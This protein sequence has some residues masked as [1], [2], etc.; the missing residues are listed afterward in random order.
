MSTPTTSSSAASNPYQSGG[1]NS[2][3]NNNNSMNGSS[4]NSR[5]TASGTARMRPPPRQQ[6]QQQS[7][8]RFNNDIEDIVMEDADPTTASNMDMDITPTTPAAHSVLPRTVAVAMPPPPAS[9]ATATA[10]HISSGASTNSTSGG[11]GGGNM[12]RLEAISLVELRNRLA[13]ARENEELYRQMFGQSFVV[14][15]RQ[16]GNK[17][18]FNIER[19]AKSGNGGANDGKKVKK[20]RPSYVVMLLL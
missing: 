2:S 12:L 16:K 3:S 13:R 9:A 5:D 17:L 14:R 1:K 11:G 7:S 18:G 20:V 6:Q 19:I 15:A 8:T 10:M 4:Q